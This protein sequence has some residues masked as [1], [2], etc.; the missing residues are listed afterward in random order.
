MDLYRIVAKPILKYEK[1]CK[2]GFI[3][4]KNLLHLKSQ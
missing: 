1:K 3:E 2:I 4:S